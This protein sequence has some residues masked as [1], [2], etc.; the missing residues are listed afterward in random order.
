MDLTEAMRQFLEEPRFAVVA[1][2]GKDGMPQQTIVWYLVEGDEIVMNT[3][4]GRIKETNLR[5]DP[6][7]SFCLEDGY[8]YITIKGTVTI[9]E[10]NAQRD[11]K[12]MAERYHDAERAKNMVR[13][14]FAK[15]ERV[16]FRLKI[17]RVSANGF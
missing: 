6:R 13:D 7:L 17:D 14:Q 1:T 9:D 2:I 10:V 8:R 11:I 16:S 4:K 12:A 3:A 15:E 5:R